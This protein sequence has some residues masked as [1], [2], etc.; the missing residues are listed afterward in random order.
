MGID[1]SGV[2]LPFSPTDVLMGA[3][4]LLSSLGGFAY[5]GL[6]FI[7]APWFI[8]LIRNFMKKREGRTA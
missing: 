5:L 6:A 3:V 8:S 7:V 2:S 4:E 1:F